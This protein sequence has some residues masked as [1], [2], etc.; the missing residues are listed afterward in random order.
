MNCKNARNPAWAGQFYPAQAGALREEV[1]RC[2]SSSQTVILPGVKAVIAPHAGYLYSGPVA[3]SAFAQFRDEAAQIQRI[4]LVGPAH[5]VAFNGLALS[6]AECFNTPLGAVPTDA[7]AT[8]VLGSCSS[9]QILD[10]AHTAEHCLEVELPF[11]QVMLDDFFVIPLLVGNATE[12]EI[13]DVLEILWGGPETRLV[14]SSDLSH[15]LD[16]DAA[17]KEDQATAKAIEGLDSEAITEAQ[18]CGRLPITGLLAAARHHQLK[19]TTL[20]LR[21]SGDT[22]GSRD[23]V[24]GYGAFAFTAN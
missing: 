19:A 18:A 8:K 6:S 22:A 23:R 11:L 5:R 4:V 10:K 15:Y 1:A 13:A 9:V 24:V 3:G 21:N 2:I 7:S 12:Q 20:D 16:Y 17:V 14:I